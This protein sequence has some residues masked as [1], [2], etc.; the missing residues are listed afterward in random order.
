D[1]SVAVRR[2]LAKIAESEPGV[3]ATALAELGIFA[4]LRKLG[5]V[6]RQ[7]TAKMPILDDIMDHDL[8]GPAIRQGME[9]GLERGREEG[10][11]E[12]REKGCEQGEKAIVVNLI[13]SRFGTVPSW[14]R[15]R[16][17]SMSAPEVESV[18]LRLLDAR[19]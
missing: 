3:R 14:V 7:E 4:G 8:L 1:E 12:G 17:E 11:Q 16:L 2:I 18:S 9:I 15:E 6:V 19:N 5:T 13:E 10:R